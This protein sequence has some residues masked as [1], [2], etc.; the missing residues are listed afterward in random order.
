MTFT[1]TRPMID[2]TVIHHSILKSLPHRE[3]NEILPAL[4]TVQWK[5][6]HTTMINAHTAERFYILTRGSL[7]IGAQHPQT[8]RWITLFRLFPGDGHD[9]ISLLDGE[10]HQLLTE[11]LEETEAVWAP[12]SLWRQ[13]LDRFPSLRTEVMRTAAARIQELVGLAEN[14]A[15]YETSTRLARAL[16]KDYE[17]QSDGGDTIFAGLKHEDIAEMIGS[18]RIVTNRLLNHF[19]HEGIIQSNTGKI[20]I[21]DLE[22]LLEKA[23]RKLF[24]KHH[25]TFKAPR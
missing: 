7:K 9:L 16:L 17:R 12:L 10:P 25:Q 1:E 2:Q 11:T 15:L 24:G 13:W 14:L 19:K 21:L 6:A 5:S 22:R 23:E 20:R 8:G 18:V 4:Q 3:L